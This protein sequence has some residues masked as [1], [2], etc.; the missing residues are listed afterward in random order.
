[1]AD[2][3]S[4]E[5]IAPGEVV[6]SGLHRADDGCSSNMAN[7]SSNR[8]TFETT[9]YRS[10]SLSAMPRRDEGG[11]SL[12]STGGQTGFNQERSHTPKDVSGP[13]F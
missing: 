6:D 10:Q 12:S 13:V 11:G 1:M 5:K 8:E 9:R 2:D 7:Y 3:S 4:E